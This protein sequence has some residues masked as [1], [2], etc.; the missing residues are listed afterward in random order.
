MC[1]AAAALMLPVCLVAK[2][3][4]GTR[5][6][7]TA[8][9]ATATA[10]ATNNASN[11]NQYSLRDMLFYI[12]SNKYLFI[13]F[14]STIISAVFNVAGS[15][16]MYL[17]RYCL[18]DEAKLGLINLVMIPTGLLVYA[19]FPF[20]CRRFD[21][22]LIYFWASSANVLICIVSFFV[23]YDNLILFLLMRSLS[24]LCTTTSALLMFMF[25]PDCVEYG[26]YKSGINASGIAFSIQTFTVKLT[27]AVSAGV[28]GLVLVYIGFIE[29]EGAVQ[30]TGFN[31]KLWTS[32][33]LLPALSVLL[34]LPILARY[35][36]RGKDVE[37]MAAV[38]AGK[39]TREEAGLSI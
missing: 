13:F 5:A 15:F 35:K 26:A 38:N 20:L 23:G 21:K 11:D 6:P 37:L 14:G 10:A 17:A 19:V 27:A 34:S 2:E 9:T 16:G 3:R 39:I 30:L 32:Y 31:N 36:L 29:G 12:K 4:Y 22:F 33:N 25:T 7:V 24:A 1:A 18:G 8:A 28:A